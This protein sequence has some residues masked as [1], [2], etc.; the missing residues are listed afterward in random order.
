MWKGTKGTY[1]TIG[2]MGA[3][4]ML[5][6]MMLYISILPNLVYSDSSPSGNSV[7]IP[8]GA[9][10]RN[11][12][13]VL[14]A[15]MQTQLIDI[16][17]IGI[18]AF[19]MWN[20]YDQI[21]LHKAGDGRNR[22]F[23]DNFTRE[24]IDLETINLQYKNGATWSAYGS[25][26]RSTSVQ[27]PNG[28]EVIK[29]FTRGSHDIY[30]VTYLLENGKPLKIKIDVYSDAL[31]TYRID[32][33]MDGVN[34]TRFIPV[35]DTI[36]FGQSTRDY[37]FMISF[38][39]ITRRFGTNFTNWSYTTISGQSRIHIYL[40]NFTLAAGQS[41]SLDPTITLH[42]DSPSMIQ[43]ATDSG[44][45]TLNMSRIYPFEQSFPSIHA[46]T[47]GVKFWWETSV[48]GNFTS[49]TTAEIN[50]NS[51]FPLFQD[52][53]TRIDRR[54]VFEPF[55]YTDPE[56]NAT[57]CYQKYVRT[58]RINN[59]YFLP[60]LKGDSF[61]IDFTDIIHAGFNIQLNKI[62]AYNWMLLINVTPEN[63]QNNYITF[64]P[65][66]YASGSIYVNQYETLSSLNSSIN[67]NNVLRCYGTVASDFWCYANAH[68]I[69]NMTGWLNLTVRQ[70]L[71]MNNSAD[72]QYIIVN[73]GN[74]TTFGA[75]VNS[76]DI[77]KRW[78]YAALDIFTYQSGI[79]TGNS[80]LTNVQ[81][82][83]FND[84]GYDW[85]DY[86]T[87]GF[88]V[89]NSSVIIGNVFNRTNQVTLNGPYHAFHNN[90]FIGNS[91]F[92]SSSGLDEFSGIEI[93]DAYMDWTNITGNKI[94]D[95]TSCGGG[96]IDY[97]IYMIGSHNNII[98]NY[99]KNIGGQDQTAG[100]FEGSSHLAMFSAGGDDT[101]FNLIENNTFTE[102]QAS[103]ASTALNG[104][105]YTEGTK[106]IFRHNRV[107][108][109][110]GSDDSCSGIIVSAGGLNAGHDNL[111][112]S[113]WLTRIGNYGI[114]LTAGSSQNNFTYNT[115]L[116][117]ADN[118]TGIFIQ[119]S[120]NNYFFQTNSTVT[121][122]AV[123]NLGTFSLRIDSPSSGNIFNQSK[124]NGT[125]IS[126]S[127]VQQGVYLFG[128]GVNNNSIWNSSIYGQLYAFALVLN[129]SDNYV[130]DSFLDASTGGSN[131][132]IRVVSGADARTN[133]FINTTLVDNTISFP[134]GSGLMDYK[135]QFGW[136][137][138]VQ[139]NDSTPIG[140]SD[141]NV[142]TYNTTVGS[143]VSVLTGTGGF[144]P[145]Q[146][147][148]QYWRNRTLTTYINNYTTN[149]TKNHY[150][151][152]SEG[153]LITTNKELWMNIT[154]I[155]TTPFIQFVPP[156][157]N[158]NTA[159]ARNFTAVN[160]SIDQDADIVKLE[161]GALN[162]ALTNYTMAN[163]TSNL[164]VWYYNVTN[165]PSD[166]YTYRVWA[167]NS[168]SQMN[169]TLPQRIRLD[170][171]PPEI[172]ASLTDLHLTSANIS[173]TWFERTIDGSIGSGNVVVKRVSDG[174]VIANI[175]STVNGTSMIYGDPSTLYLFNFTVQDDL[176]NYNFTSF[177]VAFPTLT[178]ATGGSSSAYL[179]SVFN[180]NITPTIIESQSVFGA[181]F[182]ISVYNPSSL[183]HM[184]HIFNQNDIPVDIDYGNGILSPGENRTITATYIGNENESWE[185]SIYLLA[186]SQ[187]N[188]HFI[189][190]QQPQ[191]YMTNIQPFQAA[192]FNAIIHL[193]LIGIIRGFFINVV[194][195][196]ACLGS[197]GIPKWIILL[198]IGVLFVY[199]KGQE[200][201][202]IR[203]LLVL[204]AIVAIAGIILAAVPVAT[205][206]A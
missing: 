199:K 179:P 188:V 186:D 23:S 198:I 24:L 50:I 34:D 127:T 76:S 16:S 195:T 102:C 12:T 67:N 95:I 6:T 71:T 63:I 112:D 31:N 17:S 149:A 177:Y 92:D 68:I 84:L 140:I 175:S 65:S 48:T 158:N 162:G 86:N 159:F 113:N 1:G 204:M 171:T 57:A 109:T 61:T 70:N 87:T 119:N 147:A 123:G 137:L 36:Y 83:A 153:F 11:V 131:F 10:I 20:D 90:T 191:I 4:A 173:W 192:F 28:W 104:Y 9:T 80:P 206:V 189:F 78:S 64:D 152:D 156:T 105:I 21:Q 32:W 121:K 81:N 185:G 194:A 56:T 5:L 15:S 7:Y 161:W 196:L 75:K 3:L 99:F 14:N 124:F 135:I 89:K 138:Q 44:N 128:N 190:N 8:P 49:N 42:V 72:G 164:T 108:N 182:K 33:F 169:F 197:F 154:G 13:E 85:T 73:Y 139:V 106:N 143:S 19:R 160:V 134:S 54:D 40:G 100:R 94:M 163:F 155:F 82:S 114:Y 29:T 203:N 47:N 39:D 58:E 201:L 145:R 66:F 150:T 93:F 165:Q 144:A 130:Y 200:T 110:T 205:C 88:F 116:M 91:I 97:G 176:G 53:R 103:P 52:N 202:K 168:A 136:W 35:N 96:C 27:L 79:L 37:L 62:D 120:N 51:D 125:S 60:Y 181:E 115:I 77:T 22:Y 151:T 174:S 142:T 111:F 43:I 183:A 129:A 167:N 187:D 148:W 25:Y 166:V 184:F 172:T 41:I 101:S 132:N 74:F 30:N 133:Y 18:N 141:V 59:T 178:G 107:E 98:N 117:T 157:E 46:F 69:I 193:D 146:I 45:V 118:Q 122:A 2:F 26:D 170:T 126:A 55:C 38:N 180:V